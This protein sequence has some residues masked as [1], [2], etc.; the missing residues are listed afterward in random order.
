SPQ[1]QERTAATTRIVEVTCDPEAA[2]DPELGTQIEDALRQVG[3]H[4]D[5]AGA[6]AR[7]LSRSADDEVTSRTELT[8]RLKARA[9]LGEDAARPRE[10][11][12]PRT[13]AEETCYQQARTLPF[14]TWFEFVINQQGELRRQRLSWYSPVTDH[15]LFRSEE[16]TSELQSRENL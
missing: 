1:W 3:Y 15:T 12:P 7:R 2:P 13:A 8:A 4:E 9:R 5:E 11:L 10:Q 14:G 16:H 6:I